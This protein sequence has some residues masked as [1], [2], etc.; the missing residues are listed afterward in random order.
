MCFVGT[1]PFFKIAKQVAMETMQFHIN[2]K[3]LVLRN[4]FFFWFLSNL[5]GPLTSIRNAANLVVQYRPD[6][7]MGY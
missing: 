7:P 2:K 5:I 4:T 6:Y 3:D 1:L